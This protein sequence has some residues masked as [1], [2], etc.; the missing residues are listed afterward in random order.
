VTGFDVDAWLDDYQ[1]RTVEVRICTRYDLLEQH[2]RLE[3]Q[4]AGEQSQSRRKT[5]ARKLVKIETEIEA[6]E[7]VFT[8]QDIGGVWLD[9]IGKHPPTEAQ[10]KADKNLDHDPESFPVAAVAASAQIPEL[11]LDQV[12]RLRS[13]LQFTQWQRLWGAVL[14]AN[15]GLATAPKSLLAGVVLRQNGGSGTTPARKGSPAASS[16]D[17]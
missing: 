5:L 4:L 13:K 11:T 1:P 10:L 3:Q 7:K 2:T 6:V 17:G 9:L 12:V 15:L 8:F 16:S 14:E